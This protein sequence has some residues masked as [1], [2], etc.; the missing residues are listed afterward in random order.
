MANLN[1]LSIE[2]LHRYIAKVARKELNN[3]Q[4]FDTVKTGSIIESLP[5]YYRIQLKDSGNESVVEATA[6]SSNNSF[7]KDDYVYL[8]KAPFGSGDLFT[9]KYYIFGI[10]NDT[11]EIFANLSEWER[12]ISAETLI[13]EQNYS[14]TNLNG[15]EKLE[16]IFTDTKIIFLKQLTKVGAAIGIEGIFSFNENP[17]DAVPAPSVS[18]YG[19]RVNLLNE[20]G[21]LCKDQQGNPASYELSSPYFS[22]Q[23]FNMNNL[24][25]K[26]LV[27]L[28]VLDSAPVAVEVYLYVDGKNIQAGNVT[29]SNITLTAGSLADLSNKVNVVVEQTPGKKD[30]FRTAFAS[31]AEEDVV[32]LTAT[33]YY[34]S[35]ALSSSDLKY[36][37]VVEDK[38]MAID[39]ANYSPIAG[40]GWRMMNSFSFAQILASDGA[41][42][43]SNIKLWNNKSNAINIDEFNWNLTDEF[44]QKIGEAPA[45]LFVKYDTK[46][47]CIVMYHGQR[48]ESA[49]YTIYDYSKLAVNV[50][51]DYTKGAEEIIILQEPK[52]EIALTCSVKADLYENDTKKYYSWIVEGSA[53]SVNW[54]VVNEDKEENSGAHSKIIIRDGTFSEEEKTDNTIY[55]CELGDISGASITESKKYRVKCIVSIAK[56]DE[57]GNPSDVLVEKPSNDFTFESY[58]G[59]DIQKTNYIQYQYAISNSM[60][61]DASSLESKW[62]PVEDEDLKDGEKSIFRDIKIEDTIYTAYPVGSEPY[63][64]IS[65]REV[66]RFEDENMNTVYLDWSNPII[67]RQVRILENGTVE[68]IK[69]QIELDQINNFREL[70]KNG[71]EEGIFYGK[72]YIVANKENIPNSEDLSIYYKA[73]EENGSIKYK[74][75]EISDFLWGFKNDKEYYYKDSNNNIIQVDKTNT[76]VDISIEYYSSNDLSNKYEY[77]TNNFNVSGKENFVY[78]VLDENSKLSINAS[79]ISTGALRVGDSQGDIF[80]ANVENPAVTI[81]G[82]EVTNTDLHSKDKK[83]GLSSDDTVG[84]DNVAFW[85]GYNSTGKMTDSDILNKAL[86][87]VTHEGQ[88]R[89]QDALINGL[90][91]GPGLKKSDLIPIKNEVDKISYPYTCSRFFSKDSISMRDYRIEKKVEENNYYFVVQ[92]V[93]DLAEVFSSKEY[94]KWDNEIIFTS[95]ENVKLYCSS[96]KG[97]FAKY[98]TNC[99]KIES[100]PAALANDSTF[101]VD[102]YISVKEHEYEPSDLEFQNFKCDLLIENLFQ[103]IG[104]TSNITDSAWISLEKDKLPSINFPYFKYYGDGTGQLS[105]L[106]YNTT[107]LWMGDKDKETASFIIGTDEKTKKPYLTL[108]V[109]KTADKT[110]WYDTISLDT[111]TGLSIYGN[112]NK[113]ILESS[114]ISFYNGSTSS[115]R[116]RID[117][118]SKNTLEIL[119]ADTHLGTTAYPGLGFLKGRWYLK[120]YSSHNETGCSDHPLAGIWSYNTPS[121][122]LDGDVL[123]IGRNR[124]WIYNGPEDSKSWKKISNDSDEAGKNGHGFEEIYGVSGQLLAKNIERLSNPNNRFSADFGA[125][126]I[127]TIISDYYNLY[128]DGP[129]VG[130][131]FPLGPFVYV[132]LD[133][134]MGDGYH[135][136]GGINVLIFGS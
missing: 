34:E 2:D 92:T 52:D 126:A 129:D 127:G 64:Y 47:K 1:K 118:T 8:V 122:F 67:I 111:S 22:G 54:T 73:V 117:N 100:F 57:N 19:I 114:G 38:N 81:G 13:S 28:G 63:L 108:M 23:P 31:K 5:G 135:A 115:Y 40:T 107:S 87:S 91:L 84:Q 94:Y 75:T 85:A 69:N 41:L 68:D 113:L 11:N 27:S 105:S 42:L 46:I 15:I 121:F 123:L 21:E 133:W 60:E 58:V 109:P 70:T 43:I 93:I 128:E 97:N 50:S 35:Q 82:Y 104:Y 25:Q 125:G 61:E 7:K 44:G 36:Y 101:F 32:S 88:L 30:Y 59:Q 29:V 110:N 9:N 66:I 26:R 130:T 55:Y 124:I 136:E 74:N 116:G 17:N 65:Q 48:F 12:F 112:N 99:S 89:T 37:W 33:A 45:S 53:D 49:E 131:E 24:K 56:V 62:Q 132:A 39:N 14:N 16:N 83:V 80:Y 96:V 103:Y 10:V 106:F 119:A 18:E 95:P 76:Q 4:V 98:F 77:N 51:I 120:R 78:Y 6:M 71:N 20:D 3:S 72:I 79:Y 134:A 102:F 90:I 86:Y